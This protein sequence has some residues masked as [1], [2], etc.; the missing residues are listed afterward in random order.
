MIT[1]VHLAVA[2]APERAG[3]DLVDAAQQIEG[4]DIPQQQGAVG[5]HLRPCG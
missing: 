1:M 3:V 2:G 5:H 4:G